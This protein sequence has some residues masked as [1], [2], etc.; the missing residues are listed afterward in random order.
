MRYL[1]AAATA[2][3]LFLV[4]ASSYATTCTVGGFTYTCEYNCTGT[5]L[6]QAPASGCDLNGDGLCVICGD[7]ADNFLRGTNGNDVICGFDG[8]DR[9]IGRPATSATGG[10]DIIDGGAGNDILTGGSGDDEIYGGDGDDV[11]FGG[12]GN[13]TLV[14]GNGNDALQSANNFAGASSTYSVNLCGGPGDD[15]LQGL[16]FGHQC[17]DGG[18]SGPA[19]DECEYDAP[20]SGATAKDVGTA[21][22]CE[23]IPFGS[24]PLLA[25]QPPCGCQ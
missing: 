9:I 5:A 24:S 12:R 6:C 4:A 13:D 18:D 19:G 17:M 23:Y 8:N 16:G 25:I 2:A 10:N 7:S 21:R 20:T 11:L 15:I 3:S 22:H 1:T 14:G